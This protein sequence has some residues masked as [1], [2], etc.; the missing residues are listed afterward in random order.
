MKKFYNLGAWLL[1]YGIL[2]CVPLFV[3]VLVT[4]PLGA[5]GWSV[6]RECDICWSYKLSIVARDLKCGLRIT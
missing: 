3:C 6:I 4:L 2:T 1:V 5:I